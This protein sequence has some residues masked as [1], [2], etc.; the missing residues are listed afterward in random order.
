MRQRRKID[1]F[2]TTLRDGQ[3][4]PGAGMSFEKN[5]EYARL[6]AELRIDVLEA[7][8]PAASKID[9]DIVKAIAQELGGDSSSPTIAALCQLRSEQVDLSIESL[10]PAVKNKKARLHTYVPV[11]PILMKASL[12]SRADKKGEIVEDL[13][14]FVTRAVSAGLEVEFSPEGYSRMGENLSFVTDLIRAA[15]SAGARVIN[16]PDTIGGASRFQGE[17]YFVAHMSAHAEMM[18]REFPGKEIVWSMHCHNDFGLAL[19]NSLQGAFYGPA[20]QIEGCFNGIGE[21][22]GNVALEQVIMA[23]E[24]FGKDVNSEVEL[25]SD[26]DTTKLQKLSDFIRKYMLPRQ[27]HWPIVGDNAMKHSSGGHTNAI[28]KNPLAYQPFDPREVGREIS[29]VFGPLSGGNHAKA[30]IEAAGYRCDD[31]EKADIAQY[32]K[33]VFKDRRKGVTD[34]ELLKGYFEFRKPIRIEKFEYRR[35]AGRSEVILTGSIFGRN[36]THSEVHNGDDS[37]LAALK[38]L[39]DREIPGLE[40]ESYRSESEGQGISA[41]SL[42][43]IV[44]KTSSGEYWR[45]EGADG[46]IEISA[47]KAFLDAANR[48]FIEENFSQEKKP[49]SLA[50][51]QED[52]Q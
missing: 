26:V 29:I 52:C 19:D 8:F 9:F 44:V 48:A 6:A 2:D 41:R 23:I 10:L 15:L 3:Q 5:I 22:A 42:S 40:I 11:D 4:C 38:D 27:P 39:V 1:I 31:S 20:T 37:A 32:I 17:N 46:D 28:L 12:G 50:S 49:M 21:R 14:Q 36:G 7:G 33:D 47:L 13:F 30:L 35:D 18:K 45:G 25:Y 43:T 24:H 34:E 16:C 51:F